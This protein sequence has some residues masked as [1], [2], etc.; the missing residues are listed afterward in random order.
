M[1]ILVGFQ[2]KSQLLPSSMDGGRKGGKNM[3]KLKMRMETNE[4]GKKKIVFQSEDFESV[5][6][7][8]IT[9]LFDGAVKRCKIKTEQYY[10]DGKEYCRIT[11]IYTRLDPDYN[12]IKEKYI[13]ENWSNDWGN[14]INVYDTFKNNNIELKEVNQ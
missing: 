6:N 3:E 13:I 5:V 12:E 7:W 11:A 14:F 2:I 1:K 9:A 8:T 10:T 4:E